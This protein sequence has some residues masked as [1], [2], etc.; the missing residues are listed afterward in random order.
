[1]SENNKNNKSDWWAYL[2]GVAIAVVFFFVGYM[3]C[4]NSEPDYNAGR[5]PNGFLGYSDDFWEWVSDK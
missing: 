4:C 1:M 2:I 3:S 5:D